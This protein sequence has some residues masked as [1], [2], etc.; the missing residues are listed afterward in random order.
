MNILKKELP[1][2]IYAIYALGDLGNNDSIPSIEPV[3][4]DKSETEDIRIAAF[5]ATAS[6]DL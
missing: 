2:R 4:Q 1:R 6:I 5:L 3:L